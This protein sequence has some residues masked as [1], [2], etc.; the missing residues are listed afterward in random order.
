MCINLVNLFKE[1][2][3][4]FLWFLVI[5]ISTAM[6]LIFSSHLFILSI[7]CSFLKAFWDIIKIINIGSPQFFSMWAL[8]LLCKVC[9]YD[10]LHCV[11]EDFVGFFFHF[12]LVC[13]SFKFP[14][15]FLPCLVS[16]SS[17]TSY[18]FLLLLMFSFIPLQSDRTQ[19]DFI[20]LKLLIC[21]LCKY[22]VNF[23][24]SSVT[25][26]KTIWS[27]IGYRILNKCWLDPLIYGVLQLCRFS[28]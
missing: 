6:I 16:M 12:Q 20:S 26:K 11:P 19:G 25:S 7:I 18:H 23:G 4:G 24:E 8:S 9:S 14:S 2:T 13:G 22:V 1:P 27:L 10:C 15:W 21:T 17:C 3:F 28:I 5:F